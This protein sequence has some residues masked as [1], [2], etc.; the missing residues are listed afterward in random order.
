MRRNL[1]IVLL[2]VAVLFRLPGLG[3]HFTGD[4]IDTVGP[5]RSFALTGDFR[6]FDTAA[7]PEYNFAHPPVRT[8]L[9][10][11]WAFLFGFSNIALRLVTLLSGVAFVFVLFYLG[12]ELYS[13]K[14]GLIAAFLAA[15]S[16]Y[17]VWFS[18]T[19][20]VDTGH[21]LLTTS[22]S[23]LLFVMYMKNDD[24]RYLAGSSLLLVISI[25]TKFTAGLLI[26]PVM[27]FA[28]FHKK[29]RIG[30][31]YFAV[32][33][34][35]ALALMLLI[36]TFYNNYEM[37]LQPI[38]TFFEYSAGGAVLPVDYMYNKLFKVATIT[39]QMTPFFAVLLIMAIYKLK[40]TREFWALALW[41]IAGFA[42]VILPYGQ[43][44]QRYIGVALAPTFIL[45]AKYIETFNFREKLVA[46][47]AAA[48]IL[49]SFAINLNDLM[50]YYSPLY[51][52]LFYALA[53]LALAHK[54]YSTILLVAG[55]IGLSVY[56][57][58]THAANIYIVS[59]AVHD[60][61]GKVV[62][63][64]YPYREVWAS[65][66]IA[67]YISPGVVYHN[68]IQKLDFFS[69][70]NIRKNNVTYIAFYSTPDETAMLNAM[71]LCTDPYV[72]RSYGHTIGFVCTTKRTYFETGK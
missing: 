42:A 59:D 63:L 1:L 9:F 60:L 69:A 53:C 27:V 10:S 33:S 14:V 6:V 34:A 58:F 2:L 43:D 11:Y 38:K 3:A 32:S 26:V 31:A 24:K 67:Y 47:G 5:A 44:S 4:E 57:A 61:S 15:I 8:L 29:H 49:L 68:G 23:F 12:R 41:F 30:A 56:F 22:L 16:R 37:F 66:D 28:Y 54:K 48:F 71:E 25:I 52:G 7:G 13:E 17:T 55:F 45:V 46:A 18:N 40:K 70:E 65:K 20:S 51:I 35:G 62:E 36:A 39:W 21:F 19:V 50:G 72:Y 64:G